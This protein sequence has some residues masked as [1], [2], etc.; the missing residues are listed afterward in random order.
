MERHEGS[1]VEVH[2]GDKKDTTYGNFLEIITSIPLSKRMLPVV[3]TLKKNESRF[4][5]ETMKKVEWFIMLLEGEVQVDIEG[6]SYRLL[7]REGANKGDSMYS[8]SSK[9]HI[10]KNTG[11]GPAKVLC[12]S[13]PPVL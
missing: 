8:M 5:E 6:K 11:S 4:L 2:P 13:S 3:M 9:K 12:V 1:P 7:H 10:L